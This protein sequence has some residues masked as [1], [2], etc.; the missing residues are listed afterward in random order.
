MDADLVIKKLSPPEVNWLSS[1][2]SRL[3]IVAETNA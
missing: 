3:E 2:V 1:L